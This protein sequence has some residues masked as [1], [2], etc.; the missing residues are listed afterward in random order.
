M[1]SYF[2]RVVKFADVKE[3][4]NYERDFTERSWKPD[5]YTH[6]FTYI[7]R[8]LSWLQSLC[9]KNTLDFFFRQKNKRAVLFCPIF[10]S[11]S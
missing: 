7:Q 6:I 9:E 4:Y 1:N 11:K 10:T 2:L 5:I 3:Q 8:I